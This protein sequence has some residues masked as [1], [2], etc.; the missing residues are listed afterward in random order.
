MRPLLVSKWEDVLVVSWAVPDE[1]LVPSVP[2]GLRLDRVQGKA[3]VSLVCANVASVST[4]GIR[5]PRVS[6]VPALGLA[7]YVRD[8]HRR[9]ICLLGGFLGSGLLGRAGRWLLREPA[10]SANLTTTRDG[11][12]LARGERT[13]RVTWRAEGDWIHP[14]R[15]TPE[16]LLLE[17]RFLFAAPKRGM[18]RM[19]RFEHPIWRVRERVE[20]E[21]DVDFG[22]LWGPE[23]E[24]LAGEV[25]RSVLLAEGSDVGVYPA[26]AWDGGADD[27]RVPAL[28]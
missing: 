16:H 11:L 19:I 3:M 5:W 2:A 28:T 26:R 18:T 6:D 9:G 24:F 17:R 12:A 15:D 14:G 21:I 23:W 7:F 22:A 20:P 8:T 10:E 13:H 4:W 25:P 1:I 27:R